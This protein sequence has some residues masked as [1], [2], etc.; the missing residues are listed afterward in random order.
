MRIPRQDSGASEV[1]VVG[2]GPVE[3]EVWDGVGLGRLEGRCLIEE[4]D[5][6][7]ALRW[8]AGGREGWGGCGR[9]PDSTWR[10]MAETTGGSVR[11]ARILI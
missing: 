3:L 5:E 4:P 2:Q 11:N 7:V 6:E 1:E 9:G 8:S 10:R